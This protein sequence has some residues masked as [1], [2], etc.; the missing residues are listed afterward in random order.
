MVCL[1]RV[2]GS[3]N[4]SRLLASLTLLGA[5]N[6][7]GL[8]APVRAA[9]APSAAP[10]RSTEDVRVPPG[11]LIR[12]SGEG[13][14]ACAMEGE[15][16]ES[17]GDTCWYPV[18]L[19]HAAG[20]LAISRW[21][22][23][24][25][26]S[27][28]VVVTDYPYEVQHIEIADDS[29]VNLSSKDLARARREGRTIGALWSREGPA[30]FDLPLAPPLDPM[31]EGGRFGDRRFFN[32]QP[33]SP[34]TGSDFHAEAGTPVHAAADGV[35]ALASNLFFSGNSVFLDHGDGLI[36]MY[37]HLS[38][39][40][41]EEGQRVERGQVIGKVGSTGRATGPHLHFGVRWHGERIDPATVL[42]PGTAAIVVP[43][44]PL[45][46]RTVR[47]RSASGDETGGGDPAPTIVQVSGTT[48][49]GSGG[50]RGDPA[51]SSRSI[52]IQRTEPARGHFG[53]VNVTPVRP[54][55]H[56]KK[57]APC[58]RAA[59]GTWCVPG[60]T[61]YFLERV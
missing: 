30:L 34:H 18:D 8:S 23:G 48:G 35:V 1:N 42:D 22:S 21:R 11:G 9:K 3:S 46:L 7:F 29:Q 19:L 13:T 43:A 38:E 56:R 36:T 49:R 33:R 51:G 6:I 24:K 2:L 53:R 16:W 20:P 57:A 4:V 40:E 28:Q 32:G 55:L 61:T 45:P 31:P 14:T 10:A 37:F 39:M 59:T 41:V 58:T 15:H 47:P 5:L 44:G 60:S 17:R 12:W 52:G 25:K 27:V 54:R 50:C 26:E